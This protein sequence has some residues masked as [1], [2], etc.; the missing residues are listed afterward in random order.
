MQHLPDFEI[1]SAASLEVIFFKFKISLNNVFFF[2]ISFYIFQI[3]LIQQPSIYLT[4]NY[5]PPPP[6]KII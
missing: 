4:E 5:F 2:I 3:L 6:A 1:I